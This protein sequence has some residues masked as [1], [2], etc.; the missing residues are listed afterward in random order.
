M[1]L[2]RDKLL[3]KV[4]EDTVCAGFS[5]YHRDSKLLNLLKFFITSLLWSCPLGRGSPSEAHTVYTLSF[6]RLPGRLSSSIAQAQHPFYGFPR[7]AQSS[8]SQ[9]R[10]PSRETPGTSPRRVSPSRLSHW[11]HAS[12]DLSS[13]AMAPLPC[14]GQLCCTAVCWGRL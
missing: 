9:S 14:P 12:V 1:A 3:K 5:D 10:L 8:L 6:S 2:K 11:P 7:S 4:K 13:T